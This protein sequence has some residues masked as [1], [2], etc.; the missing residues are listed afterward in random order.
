MTAQLG[1]TKLY[2]GG[3]ESGREAVM[4]LGHRKTMSLSAA[5]KVSNPSLQPFT[6]PD[7]T[8]HFPG[9]LKFACRMCSACDLVCL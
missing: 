4:R 3:P 2:H 1:S 7:L 5:A 9:R 6:E 8:E